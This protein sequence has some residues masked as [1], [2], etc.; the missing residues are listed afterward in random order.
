MA[1]EAGTFAATATNA[2]VLAQYMTNPYGVVAYETDPLFP[3]SVT[4][5]RRL[6]R[7]GNGAVSLSF[8]QLDATSGFEL[9]MLRPWKDNTYDGSQDDTGVFTTASSAVGATEGDGAY[10]LPSNFGPGRGN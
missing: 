6:V 2:Q 9:G 4:I 7:S 3:D 10:S 1:F 5:N 8:L